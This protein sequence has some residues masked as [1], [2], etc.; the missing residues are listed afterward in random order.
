K[1]PLSSIKSIAQVMREEE[2]LSSYDR[3][4]GLIV[5]EIDRLNRTVSQLLAFSRPGRADA[6]PVELGQLL[7]SITTLFG[8]EAKERGVTLNIESSEDVTLSG[9]QGA[10]LREAVGNLVLNAMQATES[11]GEV[12]IRAELGSGSETQDGAGRNESLRLIISVTDTGPGISDEA[13]G[14]VFEP[15]YTTKARGTGLGLAIVQRRAAELGGEIELTS[16][17]K[18]GRGTMFR[19]TVPLTPAGK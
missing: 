13:Q 6:N 16:P 18:A 2:A 1:N 7:D 4:L 19:L 12:A 8:N 15:F 5:S 3:D 9:A 17:V 10:A 14:R 11:G